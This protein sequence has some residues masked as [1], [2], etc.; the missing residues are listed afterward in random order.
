M[1]TV[2]M[3]GQT[4]ETGVVRMVRG[5]CVVIFENCN[6]RTNIKKVHFLESRV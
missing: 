6:F 1:Q 3:V 5:A 2:K 4:V